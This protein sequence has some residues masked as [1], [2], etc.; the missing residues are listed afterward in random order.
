MLKFAKLQL[1]NLDERGIRTGVVAFLCISFMSK[2]LMVRIIQI[3]II[4]IKQHNMINGCETIF[5]MPA[6]PHK[7]FGANK[8]FRP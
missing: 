6:K 1:K 4:N 5:E 2:F 8:T 7:K 3:P